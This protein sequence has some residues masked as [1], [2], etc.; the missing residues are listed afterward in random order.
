LWEATIATFAQS[1][2][3]DALKQQLRKDSARIYHSRELQLLLSLDQRNTF[4]QTPQSNNTPFDLRGIK[5]GVVLMGR[6]KMGVGVYNIRDPKAHIRRLDNGPEEEIDLKFGYITG[7]Y[8]YLFVH[9]RRWDIG[10]PIELGIGGYDAPKVDSASLNNNRVRTFPAGTAV[11]IH[12]KPMRWFSLNGMGG[13]RYVLANAGPVNLD[14]WFYA[15]GISLNTKN[16]YD[17]SRY[18]FK[19]RK[20]KREVAKISQP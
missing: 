1:S 19:K 5:A 16:I 15:F 17:N 12:F 9:T 11:D 3:V 14:N 6:H 13:Y 2:T 8:E 4:I 7:F 10:I 20:Y 18:Y